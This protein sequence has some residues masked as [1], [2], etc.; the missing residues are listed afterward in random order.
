MFFECSW[1]WEHGKKPPA[2]SW[3]ASWASLWRMCSRERSC[4]RP[5][6]L[7]KQWQA[8]HKQRMRCQ[9]SFQSMY[10][11]EPHHIQPM[12]KIASVFCHCLRQMP[13]QFVRKMIELL[14]RTSLPSLAT[15]A[16]A[17]IFPLLWKA[18]CY[19]WRNSKGWITVG[20]SW[21][22][23]V[24]PS[25]DQLFMN[26]VEPLTLMKVTLIWLPGVSNDL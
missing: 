13:K 19:I 26:E 7:V 16:Q 20:F 11:D 1:T 9:R 21:D 6:T 5:R 12:V 22:H 8:L 15:L 2:S 25:V 14:F 24:T 3:G 10:E 4:W 18:K 17:A 23:H